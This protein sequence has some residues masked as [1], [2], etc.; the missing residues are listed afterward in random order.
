MR[1]L[2]LPSRRVIIPRH[3]TDDTTARHD[4]L[5]SRILVAT[6]LIFVAAVLISGWRTS[7][8]WTAHTRFVVVD[9]YCQGDQS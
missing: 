7:F 9:P 1:R 3:A 6:F 4:R 8:T 2:P 5:I